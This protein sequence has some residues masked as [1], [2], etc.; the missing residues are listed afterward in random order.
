MARS[1]PLLTLVVPKSRGFAAVGVSV[2]LHALAFGGAFVVAF[3]ASGTLPDVVGRVLITMPLPEIVPPPPP[4]GPPP[5]VT[6]RL[7]IVARQTVDP[8][9]RLP[10]AT[11]DSIPEPEQPNFLGSIGIGIGD[12]V[13][14]GDPDATG[15]G[16]SPIGG[17]GG[18]AP[19]ATPAP[20]LRV[21]EVRGPRKVHYVPPVYP[22]IAIVAH[23]EGK[24]EL[25]CIIDEDGHVRSVTVLEGNAILAPAAVEA[26]R[27]WRYTPTLVT[28]VRTPV[29]MRVTV[30]FGLSR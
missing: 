12:G 25:D 9:I 6:R 1:T 27:Q 10:I 7:P 29:L 20:I 28:G 24:V 13:L 19:T 22:Q 2:V 18:P 14:G 4:P 23:I 11:P 26:V 8:T 15:T 3:G 17:L 16:A 21:S 30:N 5:G